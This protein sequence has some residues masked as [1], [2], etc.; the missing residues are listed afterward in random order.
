MRP[1][2][3]TLTHVPIGKAKTA[4][5]RAAF[6]AALFDDYFCS[7]DALSFSVNMNT[8][9]DCLLLFGSSSESTAAILTYSVS[10][11]SVSYR[12]WIV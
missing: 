1:T 11:D 8:L 6:D 9:L 4:E 3:T 10:R 5:G 7:C 12:R 2:Y